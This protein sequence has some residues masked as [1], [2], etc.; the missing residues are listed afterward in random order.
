MKKSLPLFIAC[1]S[2]LVA[3]EKEINYGP[4]SESAKK[5]REFSEIKIEHNRLVFDSK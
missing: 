1:V 4:N 3:C 2:T 5:V